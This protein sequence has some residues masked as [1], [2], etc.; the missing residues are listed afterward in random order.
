MTKDSGCARTDASQRSSHLAELEK[1]IKLLDDLRSDLDVALARPDAIAAKALL[2]D[3]KAV[4][5]TI[6]EL[7]AEQS[8]R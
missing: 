1:A 8:K 2:V 5:S 7:A 6:D 3:I 4:A